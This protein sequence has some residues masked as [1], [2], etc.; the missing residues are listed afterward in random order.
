[1]LSN[2]IP[3]PNGARCCVSLTWDVDA[4]SGLVYR[5]RERTGD[6]VSTRTFLR[7]GPNIA[8]PRLVKM[9]KS[10]ELQLTFFVPGWVI[11]RYPATIDLLLEHGH[12]IGLHGYM[13]ERSHDLSLGEEAEL[14]DRAIETYVSRVGVRPRG[15]RAP[16]FTFSGHSADLLIEAGFEYDS[17][18]MGGEMPSL[19]TSSRGTLVE[20]PI[21]WTSDDWPQYMHNRD[22]EFM[23]P[24]SAP[25]RAMEV[26]RAEFD[27][28]WEY[29]AHWI[30]VWHPFLSGRLSRLSAIADLISMMRGRGDVWFARLDQ[31]CDHVQ[32]LV[33]EN[34]WAPME[35]KL[36]F[37]QRPDL[38]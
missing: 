8:I 16:G 28:T 24:I 23:M 32:S 38:D 26:F 17:S 20:L 35:D 15:W 29:G 30:S 1:M 22:F 10:L 21:D 7:Y 3:W 18:L 2:P 12:E 33:R 37:H 27:A 11:E 25:D 6:L 13:H 36:P 31:V 19:L 4:E 34:R 9:L 5:H 14:L